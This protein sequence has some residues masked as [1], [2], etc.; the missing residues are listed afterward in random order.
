MIPRPIPGIGAAKAPYSV[1]PRP[2]CHAGAFVA[3]AAEVDLLRIGRRNEPEL[4]PRSP[5]SGAMRSSR[6]KP[7]R[8]H[9]VASSRTSSVGVAAG[10]DG[11][12]PLVA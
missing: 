4:L 11:S 12:M 1:V 2:R 6:S 3:K 8:L 10:K 7:K 5:Q 9:A